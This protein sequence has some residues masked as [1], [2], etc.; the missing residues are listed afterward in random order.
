LEDIKLSGD[1]IQEAALRQCLIRVLMSPEA[2]KIDFFLGYMHINGVGYRLVADA[3]VKGSIGVRI[4]GVPD[5]AAATFDPS[6]NVFNFLNGTNGSLLSNQGV[7]VHESTH[8]MKSLLYPFRVGWTVADTQDEAAAYVAG[9]L[10]MIYAGAPYNS[11]TLPYAKADQIARSIQGKKGAIV[12]ARDEGH[13]R[14]FVASHPVYS[15]MGVDYYSL[16]YR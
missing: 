12:P 10:Y 11:P 5:G 7:M 4:G 9:S 16:V 2:Q 1:A 3:I 15:Q 13:L 6:E 14:A 8:A